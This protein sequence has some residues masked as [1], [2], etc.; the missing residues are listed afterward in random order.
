MWCETA[1][2]ESPTASSMSQAQR[3]ALVPSD[4][5]AAGAA[6]RPQQIEDLQAGRIAERLEHRGQVLLFHTSMNIDMTMPRVKPPESGADGPVLV[7]CAGS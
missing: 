6:P 2:C 7:R 3:P 1:A 4:Q 5:V